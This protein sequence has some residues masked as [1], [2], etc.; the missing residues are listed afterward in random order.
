VESGC[1]EW[2]GKLFNDSGYGR[3]YVSRAHGK[4]GCAYAHR[5]SYQMHV[6]PIEGRL[7]VLHRC[8]N[9]KCVNPQH[10]F[11]GTQFD[12]MRD[13]FAK[14]R[15][16]GRGGKSLPPSVVREIRAVAMTGEY[17]EVTRVAN[18]FGVTAAH[19]RSIRRGDCWQSLNTETVD[20]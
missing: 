2:A 11:L 18:Q 17:G 10:L 5:F 3:F 14:G 12:N 20:A 1:W 9:R 13:M 7:Q 4:G 8:D 6:G 15:N 19:F 16:R